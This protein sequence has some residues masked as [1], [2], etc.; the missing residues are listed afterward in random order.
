MATTTIRV[1][2]ATR[3]RL[4]RARAQDFGEVSIDEVITRLLD[5]H[6]DQVLRARMRA[7]AEHARGNV[8]DLAEVR[9]IQVEMDEISAW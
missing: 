2:T 7:D 1:N 8:E 3:D 9:R 4:M 6:A 5:E